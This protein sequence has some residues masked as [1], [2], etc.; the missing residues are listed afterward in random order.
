MRWGDA[1]EKVLRTENRPLHYTVLARKITQQKLVDTKGKRRSLDLYSAI[2]SDDK[3]RRSKGKPTRFVIRKG[4]VRLVDWQKRKRES[5]LLRH[6]RA[7]YEKV[8]EEFLNKLRQLSGLEFERYIEELLVQIGYDNV[9]RVG[10]SGDRGIDILCEIKQGINEVK[11]AV[12]AKNK[13]PHNKIGPKDIYYLRG[14]TERERCSQGV[15]ITTSSFTKEAQAA[16]LEQGQ[17]P[18]MLFDADKLAEL[19]FEHEVGVRSQAIKTYA[20][21]ASFGPFRVSRLNK[22]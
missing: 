18:I 16:A 3:W 21:D 22:A 14:C 6:A 2:Y 1:V 15:F 8:K 7:E 5:D 20:L 9:K 19:A 4:V 11:T 10:G 12:Q 13:Q 17:L